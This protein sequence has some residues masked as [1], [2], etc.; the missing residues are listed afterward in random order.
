MP[1]F[2]CMSS[3]AYSSF[4]P[5]CRYPPGYSQTLEDKEEVLHQQRNRNQNKIRNFKRLEAMAHRTVYQQE[6]KSDPKI[7]ILG[8]KLR[9]RNFRVVI[10]RVNLFLC[11]DVPY[12][13]LYLWAIVN[14]SYCYHLQCTYC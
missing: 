1:L 8:L 9:Y 6:M 12:W 3:R 13:P 11:L 4:L 2:P 10:L 7:A 14:V 5:C